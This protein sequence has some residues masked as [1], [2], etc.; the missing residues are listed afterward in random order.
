MGKSVKL[1][2]DDARRYSTTVTVPL[3]CTRCRR[4]YYVRTCQPGLYTEEFRKTYVC[5]VCRGS[6]SSYRSQTVTKEVTMNQQVG[7]V[8]AMQEDSR[9][10]SEEQIKTIVKKLRV[11]N[12]WRKEVLDR[13]YNSQTKTAGA[14]YVGF[15]DVVELKTRVKG[16][17]SLDQRK[18]E[19]KEMGQK[20]IDKV[21][22]PT[23]A[24]SVSA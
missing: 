19:M 11:P 8:G 16:V 7:A 18:A 5:L 12:G 3:V 17:A 20:V 9:P 1:T 23:Q 10:V 14:V 15:C 6:R 22:E 4:T 21:L 2:E 24:E 13:Y